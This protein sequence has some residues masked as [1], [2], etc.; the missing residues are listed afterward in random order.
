MCR[1]IPS[2]KQVLPYAALVGAAG[3]ALRQGVLMASDGWRLLAN[4][5]SN[6]KGKQRRRK[7]MF[8]MA[9]SATLIAGGLLTLKYTSR[10]VTALNE[11]SN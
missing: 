6:T 10:I 1:L 9:G 11:N 3:T 5:P 8:Y 7:G 2:Y 4:D